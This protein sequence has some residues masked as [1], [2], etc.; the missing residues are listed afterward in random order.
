MPTHPY[1]FV[2]PNT[3]EMNRGGR[4][5]LLDRVRFAES[6]GCALMEVPADF[7]KNKTEIRLT[8]LEMGSFLDRRAISLLYRAESAP[9][10]CQVVLHTEPE[11]NVPG[12]LR[13][14]DERWV[15][16][17]VAMQLALVEHL[18]VP[19][20]AIEIHP[21]D[22][23]NSPAQILTGARRL[24]DAFGTAFGKVPLI[25]LE[26][27]TGQVVSDGRDLAEVWREAAGCGPELL[28][29]FGIV[30][31]IQ[32]LFTQTSGRSKNT[33]RFLASLRL[34]PDEALRAFHIHCRHGVPTLADPM[35]WQ[36]VFGRIRQLKRPLFINPEIHHS[37]RIP[38][39][40]EFC[41]RLLQGSG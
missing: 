35:P 25:F 41:R 9:P 32:Q 6:T 22:R 4:G 20:T 11:L 13:W 21:G 31:D 40:M 5:S 23:L 27:R 28:S 36:T 8:G 14:H 7:V 15:D 38:A 26:N 37:N 3:S 29:R 30:L 34:I 17:F 18:G 39:A 10:G 12:I 19:P 33:E 2:L 1:C 24:I 16:C